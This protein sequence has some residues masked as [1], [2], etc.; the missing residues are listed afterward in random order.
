MAIIDGDGDVDVDDEYAIE[1]D[2]LPGL[3]SGLAHRRQIGG[4]REMSM[5]R[6]VGSSSD[7]RCRR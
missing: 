4:E 1:G 3:F 7:I 6:G 5:R 2:V